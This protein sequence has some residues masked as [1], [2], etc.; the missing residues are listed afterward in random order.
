MLL[1]VQCHVRA[2]C[3]RGNVLSTTEVVHFV[4]IIIRGIL[5]ELENEKCADGF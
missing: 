3:F 1:H 2:H 4:I 5:R